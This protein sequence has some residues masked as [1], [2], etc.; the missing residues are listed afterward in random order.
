MACDEFGEGGN[1][2]LSEWAGFAVGDFSLIDLNNRDDAAGG[3]GEEDFF[4]LKEFLESDC[5]EADFER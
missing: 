5:F 3:L 2:L 4:G 1:Q